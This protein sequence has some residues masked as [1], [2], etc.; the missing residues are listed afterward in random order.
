MER[1]RGAD[2]SIVS[3]GDF[4]PD[5]TIFR[6]HMLEPSDLEGLTKAGAVCDVLCH[7]IDRDGN[8]VDH[9]ANQRAMAMNPL[10]LAHS[11]HLILASGGPHKVEGMVAMLKRSKP[12]YVVTDA[13]TARGMLALAAAR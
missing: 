6:Y 13:D 5:S 10:E 7:F 1:A 12:A 4:S 2:L 8:L 9:L 11:P 3:V